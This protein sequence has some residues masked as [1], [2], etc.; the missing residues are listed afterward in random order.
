VAEALAPFA[1]GHNLLALLTGDDATQVLK[2]AAAGA[3]RRTSR[4]PR[5][6]P[7]GAAL[8]AL[9][10]A[11]LVGVVLWR[12]RPTDTGRVEPSGPVSASLPDSYTNSLGMEFVRVPRGK[13]WVGSIP[14]NREIDIPAD[15]Y[16]G[17]YEVKQEEWQKLMGNNP[18]SFARTGEDRDKVKDVPDEDLKRFPVETVSWD[19]IQ[20]FL[21]RLNQAESVPGWT[22]RLPTV[23]EWQY[24]CRGG[25]MA[26]KADGAFAFYF[27]PP[28]NWIE[29]DQANFL[30]EKGLGRPCKVGS[31]KPNRLGLHD[32]YGNVVEWCEDRG[33]TEH[34]AV[35]RAKQ[36]GAFWIKADQLHSYQMLPE[37]DRFR[38]VG[39]RVA[40]VPVVRGDVR[41]KDF[42]AWRKEVAALPADQQAAAVTDLLRIRNPAFYDQVTH[43]VAGG[44][45]TELRFLTDNVTDL[46]PVQALSGLRVLLC[47]GGGGYLGEL[48]DLGPLKGL[49][50]TQLDCQESLVSDLAPLEGLPLR[51]LN[52]RATLVSDLAPLKDVKL[53]RLDCSYTQVADLGP[54]KD[55]PLVELN[56]EDTRI[57]DLTP[58]K[59]LKQLAVLRC[60][61]ALVVDLAPL[62]GLPL[63]VLTCDFQPGRD[64]A[65][66]R[67]LDTLRTINDRS[68]EEFWK[69]V[70][71]KKEGPKP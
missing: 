8:V 68:A 37:K 2:P 64:A 30:H 70:E 63:Q 29:P 20:G 38:D 19:D 45:V 14:G 16:L 10:A 33:R 60:R 34:F 47:P 25:P 23:A 57:T 1:A 28:A 69:E 41:R 67:T 27:D 46:E 26:S 12:P 18:S 21:A 39:L 50:L 58:L 44:V 22:Y 17:T 9:A 54:V 48:A 61:G 3:S 6:V 31:Y 49:P 7:V 32:T 43:R 51:V 52:C 35:G 42:D 55:M 62:R 5:V 15:Y 56:C 40:R 11:V 71:A 53:T 13:A 24:G 4:K 36:G 66:L 65:I 59:G